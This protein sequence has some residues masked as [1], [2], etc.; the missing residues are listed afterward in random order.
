MGV[1]L[2]MIYC[3]QLLSNQDVQNLSQYSSLTLAQNYFLINFCMYSTVSRSLL[4]ITAFLISIAYNKCM[5]KQETQTCTDMR[6]ERQCIL[7]LS[8][9]QMNTWKIKQKK[10]QV[11]WVNKS[12]I[13]LLPSSTISLSHS[14]QGWMI[15]Q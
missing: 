1:K 10:L 3:G 8:D 4:H 7:P 2:E 6:P 5:L 15:Y 12:C 11:L 13:S 9:K 14:P